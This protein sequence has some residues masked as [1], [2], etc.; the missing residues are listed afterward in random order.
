MKTVSRKDKYEK[1]YKGNERTRRDRVDRAP[2]TDGGRRRTLCDPD[3]D[4]GIELYAD[5]EKLYK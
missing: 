3:P 5:P 2:D 1:K 4:F